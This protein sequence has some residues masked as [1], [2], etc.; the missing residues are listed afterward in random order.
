MNSKIQYN[1]QDSKIQF[2]HCIKKG[3]ES[4]MLL[5]NSILPTTSQA[6]SD[7]EN[8]NDING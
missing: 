7:P 8:R 2:L 1:T 4:S 5:H 3:N 6:S